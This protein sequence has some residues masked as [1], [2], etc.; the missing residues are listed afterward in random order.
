MIIKLGTY[1]S[2]TA[3]SLEFTADCQFE[4][5]EEW[6]AKKA[7]EEL[8]YDTIDSFL[9]NYLYDDVIDWPKD[10]EAEGVLEEFTIK[11]FITD[12]NGKRSIY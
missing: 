4:V 12:V 5:P 8:Q 11:N 7:K 3:G 1:A 2:G 9:D 10:A 6:A